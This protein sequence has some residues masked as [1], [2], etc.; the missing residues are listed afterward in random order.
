MSRIIFFSGWY[1][2]ELC[3][4]HP[5]KVFVFGDNLRRFGMG[6]QAVIRNCQ[7]VLGIATKRKPSR[8]PSAYFDEDCTADLDDVLK[9]LEALWRALQVNPNTTYVIPVTKEGKISLGLD[10]AELPKRAPT[11]YD[12]IVMHIEEMANV[13]GSHDAEQL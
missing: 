3:E 6:G 5:D 1:S 11:I 8:D 12:T 4:Q 7:N 2:P 9:D 10:R 13:Y